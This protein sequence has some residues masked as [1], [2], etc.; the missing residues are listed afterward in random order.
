[1]KKAGSGSRA[2]KAE[3]KEPMLQVTAQQSRFHVDADNAPTSK[4][5]WI[6]DLTIS[7]GQHELLNRTEVHLQEGGRYVLVGRNGGGKSTLLNALASGEIPG[8]ALN[9][10]IL[11]LGQ[12]RQLGLDEP[13]GGLSIEDETVLQHIMRSDKARERFLKEAESKPSKIPA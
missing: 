10:R 12:T 13:I 11:L 3:G 2:A 1:M 6:K 5:V 7:I 8:V 4:D 9:L